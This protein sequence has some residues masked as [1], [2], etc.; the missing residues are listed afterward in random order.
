[1][2]SYRWSTS[3]VPHAFLAACVVL[4]SG[5]CGDDAASGGHG[6]GGA[7]GGGGAGAGGVNAGAGG[8]GGEGPVDLRGGAEKGPFILGSS[9]VVSV[10]DSMGNPTGT[11][12]NTSVSDD[13]GSFD[14]TLPGPSQATLEA[15]GYYF[16]EVLG[17]LS[18]SSLTLR[19]HAEI[20]G[21]SPV[22][23]NLLTHL[24]FERVAVL[25]G[26]GATLA[27]AQAQA[28]EELRVASGIGPTGFDPGA[29]AADVT[30]LQ[31]DDAASA[32]LLAVGAVWIQAAVLEAG[33]DGPVEATFQEL[34]NTASTSFAAGGVLPPPTVDLLRQAEHTLDGDAVNAN[35]ATR[36]TDIGVQ[37]A[38]PNLHRALDQD[39]DDV[40]NLDDNCR[41][42][43]NTG[44][45]DAD[46]DG[47]GDACEC[48][49][50]TVDVGEA[51]DDGNTVSTDGCEA[52]CS[53]TC[54]RLADLPLIAGLDI[55]ELPNGKIIVV[56]ADE[57]SLSV[58]AWGVDPVANTSVLLTPDG[59][60]WGS[61]ALAE[62]NGEL[63]FFDD[64]TDTLWKT[65]GTL[66]G[67]VNT[68]IATVS[69]EVM[70][71][72]NGALYFSSMPNGYLT[73]SDGT[74]AGT[75]VVAPVIPTQ[76][77]PL[78]GGLAFVS[79]P[80]SVDLWTSDGTA[81]GTQLV[82][83][84]GEAS[85]AYLRSALGLGFVVFQSAVAPNA[86]EMWGTD[87]TPGGTTQLFV[88]ATSQE[89]IA[90]DGAE[91]AGQF[92]FGVDQQGMVRTD[93]TVGGTELFRPAPPG[94]SAQPLGAAGGRLLFVVGAPF[95]YELWQT[96]TTGT[97]ASSLGLTVTPFWLPVSTG[98]RVYFLSLSGTKGRLW[99]SDAT[100]SG[101]FIVDPTL[102]VAESRLA[103]RNGYAW[104]FGD[105]GATGRD[106]W[107]CKVP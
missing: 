34:I 95:P 17:A 41:F 96:D 11:Q 73:R 45:E 87:G 25:V 61:G 32:Y 88:G 28:E 3:L 101:T 89:S 13:A 69:P 1:M 27:S 30:L 102:D 42:V 50:G 105:D 106:P 93:G 49:N 103:V 10:V 6:G 66:A 64:L 52:D 48:G 86:W 23:V 84:L 98:T 7:S 56:G 21:G 36:L 79:A 67:T 107:R 58:R 47:V 14:V 26:Q 12:F 29:S 24:T 68:G 76:L 92:Y 62:L 81:G 46:G 71:S 51:C 70:L 99:S 63:Y 57:L 9:I 72:F 90:V 15:S 94:G 40:A 59:E 18:G 60:I 44:Q 16:N 4:G 104:V 37:T 74:L 82:A 43:A 38:A 20:V 2:R 54:E 80:P 8:G 65:D 33:I 85:Y 91:F 75:S 77:T 55:R 22:Y 53:P 31:G 78:G 35:L 39:D 97:L 83:S 100:M 19:A 5:G